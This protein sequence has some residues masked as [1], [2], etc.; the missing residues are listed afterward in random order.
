[1]FS[2]HV[3]L[4]AE[5]LLRLE[6]WRPQE[7]GLEHMRGVDI[8]TLREVVGSQYGFFIR[9]VLRRLIEERYVCCTRMPWYYVAMKDPRAVTMLELVRLFHGDICIGEAYCSRLALGRMPSG[10]LSGRNFRLRE[11]EIRE[12]LGRMLSLPISDF[13]DADD[14]AGVSSP[15]CPAES[16]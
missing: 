3:I 14:G 10:Y 6:C 4:A 7:C 16:R 13:R 8:R 12:S 5:A 1:M 9:R 11:T 2:Q 15:P